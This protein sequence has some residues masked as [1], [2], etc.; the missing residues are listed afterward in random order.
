VV[1]VLKKIREIPNESNESV[2]IENLPCNGCWASKILGN[3]IYCFVH[4][5]YS[6]KRDPRL[7]FS[8]GKNC[9]GPKAF[10]DQLHAATKQ[11]P[12]S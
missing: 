2:T 4:A 3:S 1:S 8:Q 12:P 7:E 11:A 9:P 10:Q 5:L 6:R